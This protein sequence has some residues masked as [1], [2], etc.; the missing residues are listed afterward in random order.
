MELRSISC[1]TRM[2]KVNARFAN[3][4]CPRVVYTFN[5]NCNSFTKKKI[6]VKSKMLLNE[7]K[8]QNQ[9][10]SRKLITKCY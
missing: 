6:N 5:G 9:E 1:V 7:N 4:F 8:C 3:V 2:E 10:C